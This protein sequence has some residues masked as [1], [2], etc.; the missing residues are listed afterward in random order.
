[1]MKEVL[2]ATA[3]LTLG[4][5]KTRTAALERK[6]KNEAGQVSSITYKGT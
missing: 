6:M 1:M 4:N 5:Q 2:V 3:S